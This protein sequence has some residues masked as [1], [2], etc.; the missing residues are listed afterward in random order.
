MA[1]EPAARSSAPAMREQMA[2]TIETAMAADERLALLLAD[3][4]VSLFSAALRRFPARALN[5]GIME[6]AL[7]SVGAGMALE[8][9]IPVMHSIAP[10]LVERT[11]EQIKD[12][13]CFQRLGGNFI[14]IG[15]SYDYSTEGMTHHAPGDVQ[16]LSSLPGMRITV[17]GASAEFDALFRET[18]ASGAPVYY[19]LGERQN[20][21]ALPVRFGHAET[22]RHGGRA[23][24]LAVGPML[25]AT[26]E[27]VADLDV[28][29]LYYTTLAP[30]DADTL[31]AAHGADPE[32]PVVLVEPFYAGTLTPAVVDALAPQPVRVEA[33]GVPR[34]VL[35]RYG[36]RK[37]HDAA[38][39]LDTPGIRARLLR[40]LEHE[41]AG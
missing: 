38:L 8:G 33:I 36:T 37:Q 21:R 5:L 1:M 10:F 40:A 30:F 25:D 3:I 17:P 12:D 18:Y 23:T 19:R 41:T 27:A 32:R 15:A 26:A 35:S 28:S 22:L 14:S 13:F 34:E 9:F 6:Q 20:A 11:F 31:R 2:L 16:I 4:S 29:L 39:G 7:V 24:V